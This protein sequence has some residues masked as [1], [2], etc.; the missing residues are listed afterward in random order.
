MLYSEEQEQALSYFDELDSILNQDLLQSNIVSALEAYFD[1]VEQNFESIVRAEALAT[2]CCA[3]VESALFERNQHDAVEYIIDE[4]LKS[5][6]NPNML[7]SVLYFAGESYPFSL[8]VMLERGMISEL[9]QDLLN[10]DNEDGH[11]FSTM[12]LLCEL[13]QSNLLASADLKLL[14]EPLINK[15]LDIVEETQCGDETL[16]YM[17]IQLIL[18]INAQFTGERQGVEN[19]VIK[20]LG[21]RSETSKSFGENLLFMMNRGA[22]P[23]IQLLILKF[24]YALFTNDVTYDYFY[25]NDLRVLVDVIIRE[26]YDLPDEEAELRRA[27]LEVLPPLVCNTQYPD[28]LHKAQDIVCLLEEL[29]TEQA[30]KSTTTEVQLIVEK[31]RLECS[32][33]LI[34]NFKQGD[35]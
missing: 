15:L 6:R 1:I 9:V 35:L 5:S 22:K 32:P 23:A 16:N 11:L 18:A 31:V 20:V 13:C 14:R 34:S 19:M 24:L 4:T 10:K 28:I 7:N 30:H 8:D 29:T 27:Y 3:L 12:L 17:G 33:V 26:L 25:T 2:I 21:D